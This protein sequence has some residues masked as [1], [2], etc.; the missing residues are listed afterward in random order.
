MQSG[1]HFQCRVKIAV[2]VFKSCLC[3]TKVTYNSENGLLLLTKDDDISNLL[4]ISLL[5]L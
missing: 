3:H 2:L 1:V 5:K 4:A